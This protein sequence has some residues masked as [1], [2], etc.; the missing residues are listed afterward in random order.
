MFCIIFIDYD[1]TFDIEK[2]LLLFFVINMKHYAFI[3]RVKS[4]HHANVIPGIKSTNKRTLFF[5]P[6]AHS[7]TALPLAE[8]PSHDISCWSMDKTITR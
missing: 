1:V 7:S 2:Y 4:L 3:L 6:H 8:V 5:L